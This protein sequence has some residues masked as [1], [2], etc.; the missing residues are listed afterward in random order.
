[1]RVTTKGQ[2]T[3]PTR[4]RGYLDIRPHC[5]V[6]FTIHEGRVV[7]SKTE[8]AAPEAV[9]KRFASMRGVLGRTLTT[10]EWLRATRG[11]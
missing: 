9:R 11:G 10:D 5:D 2:V 4:I 3:I 8:D 7:L 6:E 1:M